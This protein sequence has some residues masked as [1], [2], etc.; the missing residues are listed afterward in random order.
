[1]D[2]NTRSTLTGFEVFQYKMRT[3]NVRVW[4][5]RWFRGPTSSKKTVVGS[6]NAVT[7]PV[8]K[9]IHREYGTQVSWLSAIT[10]IQ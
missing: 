7:E 6:N 8:V 3:E 9:D 1:M 5:I 10:M 4:D 2:Y